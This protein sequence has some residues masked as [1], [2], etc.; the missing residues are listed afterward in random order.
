MIESI[1]AKIRDLRLNLQISQDNLCGNF[2]S[3][4]ILSRIENGKMEP[5]IRQI[6]YL[7]EKLNVPISYFFND[8]CYNENV[9]TNVFYSNTFLHDLFINNNFY[10]IIKYYEYQTHDFNQI[11]DF[12]KY[13]YLGISYF[14]Q[15]M[16]ND[17]IKPLKNTLIIIKGVMKK[18][19][20]KM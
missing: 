3:R 7:A 11:I 12:N 15:K 18:F 6:I 8:I 14:N 10:E 17:S 16:F 9:Q 5:S 4:S 19:K 13:Y 1:G 2:M 20:N